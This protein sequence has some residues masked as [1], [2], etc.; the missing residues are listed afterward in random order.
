MT[1]DPSLPPAS[2]TLWLAGD[3]VEAKRQALRDYFHQTTELY[4]SL[5][6]SLA[7]DDAWFKKAIP[8]RHPLI[9]Y[10]GH[11]AAFFIN[12]LLAAGLITERLDPRIEAMV[13]IGVDEMSWDDLDESHYAWPSVAELRA[14]RQRVR[15][16]VDEFIDQLPLTLPITWQ[17]PAWVILMGIEHERIHLETSSVLIRQLPLAWVRP[18][19]N[20]P[21][22]P[23]ARET[24]ERVPANDLVAVPGGLVTLGKVA[25]DATYGW[26][27][28]YGQ[29]QVELAPFQ[30]SR[31]LVSN[32]EFLGFVQA[33]GYGEP[34][35]WSEEGWRWREFAQASQPSFWLGSGAA[36][37]LRLMCCE[38]A[39]PWD[40][41]VEVNQLEAEAFC[42]WQAERTGLSVQL[43]CEAEWYQLR[44]RLPVEP[45]YGA[46]APGN[47]NLEQW[48]SSCPV[49]HFAQGDFFDLL[50]NVWQWSSSTIDGFDGFHVHPL[51]DDFST[52]T[53]DGK[54]AL[55]KGGSWISTGN[56]AI[57]S[58]RYAF[59]RHFFQHAGFR[60]VVSRHREAPQANPY[61][62]DR[63]LAQALEAAYGPTLPGL[64]HPG[65]HL[66]RLAA[67]LLPAGG[68]ALDMG[69]GVGRSSLELARHFSQVEGVDFSARYIDV[70]LS[71]VRQERF[72]YQL[73]LEGEL[74]EYREARL[75]LLGLG[76][77][78]VAR[79][80]FSQGDAC[81]LKPKYQEYD[82]VLAAELLDEL[83]QPRT[84]LAEVARRL[85][86]GGVLILSSSYQWQEAIT[87]KSHWLGGI[88]EN[89]EVLGSYQGLQRLLAA[90]FEELGA[91]QELPVAYRLSGRRYDYRL[92][93]VTCWRRRG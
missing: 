59:R 89:G 41:P 77:Q 74:Q 48:A 18:L 39:M 36:R 13:A 71:L 93:Q 68:K 58:S 24:P 42:R 38:V 10:F 7:C 64:E 46:S 69:C 47:I 27:N 4:E 30:A 20:W 14:Y 32:A 3:D 60:Y 66:A 87:P 43:P 15:S 61:L 51:Y 63:Q 49:D 9:F 28:E 19:P 86:P 16:R 55:I 12:K 80:Q 22:C 31:M 8:L 90:E 34:R 1:V 11:T 23:L 6:E 37:R 65:C 73:P 45:A 56:L 67:E 50:G 5:F 33:G 82:L 79:V 81:N 40:W 92:L 88:R 76:A 75:S 21:I 44:D 26:D 83:R 2:H 72:A 52:P 84:F 54:H 91:P 62:Q 53:F 78:Q 17:S 70:A 25:T 35:W 57:R 29:R 85:K